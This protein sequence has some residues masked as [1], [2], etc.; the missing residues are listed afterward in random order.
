M[1]VDGKKVY[2]RGDDGKVITI[3]RDTRIVDDIW[4]IPML[5]GQAERIGYPTQKP[6]KLLERIINA[7]SNK[8]ELIL[9]PFCGCGTAMAVAQKLRRQWVGIDITYLAI[10]VIAKRLQ[11][12]G[13]IKNKD[14]FLLA[15]ANRSRLA[16]VTS[17]F[18]KGRN[19][20]VIDAR[21][22]TWFKSYPS[23]VSIQPPRFCSSPISNTFRQP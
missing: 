10:D 7:S 19:L 21:R 17:I 9:D 11:I 20:Y 6:E 15:C 18:A 12:S 13:Y 4:K 8:G 5:M 22:P 23:D 3:T 14:F 2:V 1:K 16:L